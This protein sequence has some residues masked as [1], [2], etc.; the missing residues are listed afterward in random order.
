VRGPIKTF[1]GDRTARTRAALEAGAKAKREAEELRAQ[2]ERDTAD[3]PNVRARLVA[4][5]RETAERERALMMEKARQTAERIRSD[6]KLSAEQEA[7]AARAELR[8]ATVERA[9]AE[10]IRLVREAITPQDQARAVDEFVN[11]ARAL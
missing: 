1:L 8:R 2:L 6:A 11:S 3:L 10:A 5:L 4:E 7:D 9:L